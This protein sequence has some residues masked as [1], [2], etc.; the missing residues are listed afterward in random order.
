VLPQPETR[1]P[2]ERFT[3]RGNLRET[4]YGWLRLTPAYSV[5]FVRDLVGSYRGHAHGVLDP[6]CGTGTTLLSAAEL[7]VACDTVDLNPFLIWLANAKSRNYAD[8]EISVAERAIERMARPSQRAR[9]EWIP[10]LYRIERWW[11]PSVLRSLASAYGTLQRARTLPE[12]P[13]DLCRVAFCRALIETSNA[14]FRHQSMSF[15]S[16]QREPRR[17][18]VPDVLR[19]AMESI[20]IAAREPLAQSARRA[21]VGDAR[22]LAPVLGGKRYSAIITSPPYPNRMSYIRELR[23]YMYWLGYLGDG[24][25]AGELDWKLIGGTWGIATSNLTAWRAAA[26]SPCV[27][28]DPIA[29]RIAERSPVL[30]RYV[31]KYFHDM[32]QHVQSAVPLLAPGGEVHYVLG[33]S[34]FYDVMV[35][36]QD[37]LA[38]LFERAGLKRVRVQSLRKRTSKKELFEYLISAKRG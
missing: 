27:D 23:P 1:S 6:F 19:R 3:F 2:R 28:L 4:R 33:N 34:K 30:A 26:P 32:W 20:G 7:G 16:S 21:L 8:R 14:S 9:P 18:A 15:A 10:D 11:T 24:R 12:P 37:L 36:A 31:S 29:D 13:R 5:H 25:A 35:P 22:D 38:A 17:I